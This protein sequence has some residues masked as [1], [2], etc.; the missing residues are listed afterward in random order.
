MQAFGIWR[1]DSNFRIDRSVYKR[2]EFG[3]G[4]AISGS[5][6][7]YMSTGVCPQTTCI[8]EGGQGFLGRAAEVTPVTNTERECARLG[9]NQDR[10]FVIHA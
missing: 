5:T 8:R 10:V 7:Q 4:I 2:L 6:D 1:G 9:R 3:G